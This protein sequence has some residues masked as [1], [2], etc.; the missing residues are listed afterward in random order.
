MT[1]HSGGS[2]GP[3]PYPAPNPLRLRGGLGIWS[4]AR[5]PLRIAAGYAQR[6]SAA[7]TTGDTALPEA[8]DA[9]RAMAA[10]CAAAKTSALGGAPS[11]GT[12]SQPGMVPQMASALTC[13]W[14]I[15][16]P[17][18][19]GTQRGHT[20]DE[21]GRMWPVSGIGERVGGVGC[22]R[23]VLGRPCGSPTARR[24]GVLRGACGS[25]SPRPVQSARWREP[26]QPVSRCPPA[27][28]TP[29]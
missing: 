3:T 22:P 7:H 2:L 24:S 23:L 13:S 21:G 18:S 19:H 14:W 15:N 27:R 29:P 25:A 20:G 12:P 28:S 1:H 16:Q 4:S 11:C 8:S 17:G 9:R 5:F 10:C 6:D 26:L